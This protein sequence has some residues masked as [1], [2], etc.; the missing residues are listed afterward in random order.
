LNKKEELIKLLKN[1]DFMML[2]SRAGH[3]KQLLSDYVNILHDELSEEACF[4][5]KYSRLLSYC[6]SDSW[7]AHKILL[8]L[9]VQY[10][11]NSSVTIGADKFLSEE[12]CNWPWLR[13]ED[14]PFCIIPNAERITLLGEGCFLAKMPD[15]KTYLWTQNPSEKK[16]V[17][18]PD[19]TEDATHKAKDSGIHALSRGTYIVWQDYASKCTLTLHSRVGKKIKTTELSLDTHAY[20]AIHDSY[21]SKIILD[22]GNQFWLL[23][24]NL[25]II[26]FFSFPA[27]SGL[28]SELSFVSAGLIKS[29]KN[30]YVSINSIG[31]VFEWVKDGNG[32]WQLLNFKNILTKDKSFIAHMIMCD[33]FHGSLMRFKS[34][35]VEFENIYMLKWADHFDIIKKHNMDDDEI[36]NFI[37]NKMKIYSKEA[38]NVEYI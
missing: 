29:D 34:S 19:E 31:Y 32:V 35:L 6:P 25:I 16:C 18:P 21:N 23:D 27:E 12:K 30:R 36:Y 38:T 26:E 22:A 11:D 4:F 37:D 1:F 2:R 17:L 3:E 9:A 13:R 28:F 33:E 8:Q 15:K 7:P 24:H 20:L 14:R 10:A 5:G